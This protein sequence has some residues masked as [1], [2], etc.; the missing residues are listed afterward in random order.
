MYDSSGLPHISRLRLVIYDL[1]HLISA[2]CEVLKKYSPTSMQPTL[3]VGLSELDVAVEP[4]T[5]L[6]S[7][8]FIVSKIP[9]GSWVE[10]KQ[11]PRGE[12]QNLL[13]QL[14]VGLSL[15]F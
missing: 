2:Y 12:H 8:D 13:S 9:R 5:K 11:Q 3:A 14:V 6:K 15:S 4:G 1:G 7:K 10:N